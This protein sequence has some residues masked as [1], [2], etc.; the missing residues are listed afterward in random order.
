MSSAI[1]RG[2]GSTP[3]WGFSKALDLQD[4]DAVKSE[5]DKASMD[6]KALLTQAQA[7]QTQQPLEVLLVGSGDIR[8]IFKTAA[9]SWR[10]GS[11][12][13]HFHVMETQSSVLARHML[14]LSALLEPLDDISITERA[15]LFLECYGNLLVRQKTAQWIKSHASDLIRAITDGKG[16]LGKLIDVSSLKFRERDDIEFVFK[17]WRDDKRSFDAKALWDNRLRAHYGVRYDARDNAIDWD[18]H[19]KV[20]ETD[21][22]TSIIFKAEFLRW[23]LHGTAFEVRESAYD[24]ANRS[25][26]TVDILKQ[27]GV[28]VAKW[29]YFSDI[30]FGPY[31]AFGLDTEAKEMLK[32]ANDHHKHTSQE[33]S[34]Y[35]VR[36]LIHELTTGTPYDESQTSKLIASP[37]DASARPYSALD[38]LK[39]SYLPC[40]PAHTFDK[41]R[42]KLANKF[43]R[44]VLSN[45]MAHKIPDAAHLLHPDGQMVVETAKYMIELNKDQAGAYRDK[46]H[47][48]A[49]AAGLRLVFPAKTAQD[50]EF[51]VYQKRNA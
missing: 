8:H 42:A 29:G 28:G 43:H 44:I 25:M 24:A 3:L 46:I 35:N 31:L 47:E 19:F 37:A 39:I 10:H 48:M 51:F 34:E 23:R 27:D 9:R 11:R 32:T 41:K 7:Q 12:P 18:Y 26:A 40:D 6:L 14:L 45:G 17:Y 21:A 36:S 38:R 20:R 13:L 5:K 22:S 50:V 1:L 4:P 2:T 49:V 16:I 15:E 30:L 33:I